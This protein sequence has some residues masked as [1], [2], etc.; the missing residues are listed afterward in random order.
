MK[1]RVR[2]F[3]ISLFLF[4]TSQVLSAEWFSFGVEGGLRTNGDLTGTL[5]SES[6]RY[7]VGPKVEVALPL[8]LAFEVDA[9][10][11]PLGFTGESSSFYEN[12][13]I[14]ERDNSWEFPMILKYRLPLPLVKP[15]VGVGYAP[16]VVSGTDV[17]SG[18]YLSNP[19]T[20]GFAYFYNQRSSTNYPTTNGIVVSGGVNLDVGHVR[21]SPEVRYVR[22]TSPFLNEYGG[23]GSFQYVSNQNEVFVL[24]GISFK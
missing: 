22:W 24:L 12:S 23:D 13:I 6:K 19:L 4:L 11:R 5:T 17:S 8:H 16:R 1:F 7:I 14:R 15:F 2:V 3:G 18:G 21:F 10:Y 9:L 20:G